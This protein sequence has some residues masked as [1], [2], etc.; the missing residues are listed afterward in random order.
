VYASLARCRSLPDRLRE[1]AD[2][3]L[4]AA[5]SVVAANAV[6]ALVPWIWPVDLTI[7]AGGL[8]GLLYLYGIYRSGLF[9]LSPVTLSELMHQDPAGVLVTDE[10]LR[11]LYANESAGQLLPGVDLAADAPLAEL[12]EPRLVR[13]Q[14][15]GTRAPS[16]DLRRELGAGEGGEARLYRYWAPADAGAGGEERWLWIEASALRGGRRRCLRLR[17][18]TGFARLARARRDL[19][20]RLQRARRLESLGVFAGGL[21]HQLRNPLAVISAQTELALAR[22][23]EDEEPGSARDA[24]REAH[25]Q[26]R[27]GGRIIE[28]LLRFAGRSGEPAERFDLNR[29]AERACAATEAELKAYGT[30]LRTRLAAFAIPVRIRPTEI[31]LVVANALRNASEAGARCIEV[32]THQGETGAELR[33]RD[34]GPGM[35]E[36]VRLRAFEP[37]FTTRS[38]RGGTGLGLSV[39]HGIVTSHGGTLEIES[40][41]G[42]GCALRIRLPLDRDDEPARPSPGRP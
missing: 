23:E 10:H 35:P 39:A 5:F 42:R 17:D 28:A 1:Q 36:R 20:L 26:A 9:D 24:L 4:A 18:A 13:Y 40:S 25:E 11:L 8:I 22:L 27:R 30:L 16:S 3:L 33:I 2:V 7:A 34:D 15:P 14:D 12:L 6:D 21:A 37:F 31:E 29:A 32:A 38:A 41:P 19:E